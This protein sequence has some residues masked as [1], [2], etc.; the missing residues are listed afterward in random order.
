MQNKILY[1]IQCKKQTHKKQWNKIEKE[2]M[3]EIHQKNKNIRIFL[4]LLLLLFLYAN[5]SVL[6][7]YKFKS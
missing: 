2:K 4:L 1:I 7:L 6:G 3:I 5:Q